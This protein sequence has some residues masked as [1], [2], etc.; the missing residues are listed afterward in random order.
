MLFAHGLSILRNDK[1]VEPEG[2]VSFMRTEYP[3]AFDVRA[4]YARLAGALPA[5]ASI[6]LI[7]N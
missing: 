2:N 6:H 1:F 3:G 4:L 7:N 5:A